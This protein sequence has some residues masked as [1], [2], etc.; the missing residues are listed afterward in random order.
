MRHFLAITAVSLLLAGGCQPA[1]RSAKT[2][3]LNELSRQADYAE[4]QGNDARAM[5]L[6][7]EFVERRPHE[8]MARHRYGLLL[9]RNGDPLAAVEHIRVARDLR[10]ARIE[11]LESLLEALHLAGEKDELF[12][13]LRDSMNEGGLAEGRMRYATYAM[14]SGLADEAEESLRI[15][16]ALEGTR[17]V[18]PYQL[19]ADLARQTGDKEREV[20]ALRTVLWFNVSDPATNQRLRELGVIPGPSLATPP[21][22]TN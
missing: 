12:Q 6:W 15:A 4:L 16:A 17:S 10:P 9:M 11:Y 1:T 21:R 13:L 19:M 8:P 20:E 2:T 14:R 7:G 5:E 18:R 3:P 22:T